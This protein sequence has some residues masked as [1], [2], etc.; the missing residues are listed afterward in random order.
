MVAGTIR[1]HYMSLQHNGQITAQHLPVRLDPVN[2]PIE[3]QV[4]GLIPVDLWDA[5]IL[6]RTTPLPIRGD[7]LIDEADGTTKYSVWGHVYAYVNRVQF[8]VSRPL[9]VVP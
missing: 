1:T 6:N 2:I 5:R 9:G 8:R 7:Y 3:M 4:Q